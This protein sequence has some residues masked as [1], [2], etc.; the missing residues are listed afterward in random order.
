MSYHNQLFSRSRQS[1][2]YTQLPN[3]I[4]PNMVVIEKHSRSEALFKRR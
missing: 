4:V 1:Q 2:D 3:T